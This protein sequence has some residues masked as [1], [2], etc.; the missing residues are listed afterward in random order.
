M[1]TSEFF[2]K[3][4]DLGL[5]LFVLIVLSKHLLKLRKVSGQ[6][7]FC[8]PEHMATRNFIFTLWG[9]ISTADLVTTLGFV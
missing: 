8:L 4:K 5:K 3:S 2:C 1:S 7:G 6:I 9:T